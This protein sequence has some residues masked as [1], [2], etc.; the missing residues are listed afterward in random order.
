V[1]IAVVPYARKQK[2]L[3]E[4]SEGQTLTVVEVSL[5][6]ITVEDDDGDYI[7]FDIDPVGLPRTY[8]GSESEI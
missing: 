6:E 8:E 1:L 4:L 3:K 7:T 5:K 2:M